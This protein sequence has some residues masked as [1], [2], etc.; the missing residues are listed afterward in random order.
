MSTLY[1]VARG[2]FRPALK[3]SV[4]KPSNSAAS[5]RHQCAV[6]R[7]HER[8]WQKWH[9]GLP[10]GWGSLKE[11]T[12]HKVN[13]LSAGQTLTLFSDVVDRLWREKREITYWRKCILKNSASSVVRGLAQR[14]PSFQCLHI[15]LPRSPSKQFSSSFEEM[16]FKM[17]SLRLQLYRLT[18]TQ[19]NIMEWRQCLRVSLPWHVLML[20]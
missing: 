14:S 20:L 17:F 1:H 9:V 6:W 10:L 8:R 19:D 4:A 5:T 11:K 7:A 16:W 18:I 12:I 3:L 2:S 15:A 13:L